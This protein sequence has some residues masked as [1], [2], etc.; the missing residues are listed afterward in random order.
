MK[1]GIKYIEGIDITSDIR[2]IDNTE[3]AKEYLRDYAEKW[4]KNYIV[5]DDAIN[6]YES[7]ITHILNYLPSD[8]KLWLN[9]YYELRRELEPKTKR[10]DEQHSK[11]ALQKDIMSIHYRD[12][13]IVLATNELMDLILTKEPKPNENAIMDKVYFLRDLRRLND[14][15]GGE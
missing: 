15:A 3:E 4:T 14:K 6:P 12:K 1:R 7:A 10:P 13:L 9:A 5:C 8:K 11:I 2:N